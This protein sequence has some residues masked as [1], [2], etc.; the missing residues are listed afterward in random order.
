MPSIAIPIVITAAGAQPADPVT[1]Q[2]NLISNAQTYAPGLT[3]DLPG[4]LITDVSSTAVG[5]LTVTDSAFVAG[6]NC[7]APTNSN[8]FVLTQQGQ[9]F[10]IPQGVGSNAQ[11]NE[12]FSGPAGFVIP[13]GFT[14]SDG[15]NQYVVQDGGIIETGGQS[16]PLFC[17]AIQPG[18]FAIPINTVTTLVTSI[19]VGYTI[20]CTN[21]AV[22]IPATAAQTI[23]QYR[24]QVL[25][26]YQAPAIG[27]PAYVKGQIALV[28]GVQAAT[29]L[30]AAERPELDHGRGRRRSLRSGLRH[31]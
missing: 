15:T 22:G 24:A 3:A 20:T 8:G 14:V 23:P 30:D 9:L 6:I 18:T 2:A 10:G 1:L 13:Q 25:Q 28:S 4:A 21:P 17:I 5:A 16:A 27:T 11:V 26:A 29:H 19:P 31:L 7:I 12:V